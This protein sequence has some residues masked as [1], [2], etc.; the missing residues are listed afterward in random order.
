[1]TYR[2]GTLL[3]WAFETN[4]FSSP[5]SF[6]IGKRLIGGTVLGLVQHTDYLKKRGYCQLAAERKQG[7]PQL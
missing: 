2:K 3:G 1:M 6:I 5:Y 7:T 4:V